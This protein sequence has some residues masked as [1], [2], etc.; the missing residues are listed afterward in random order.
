MARSTPTVL[1]RLLSLRQIAEQTTIPRSTL[2]GL[3]SSGAIPAI[4]IRK[5]IR[6][7]EGDWVAFVAAHRERTA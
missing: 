4:R 1:P 7:A 3:V 5:S 6:V 2:Y